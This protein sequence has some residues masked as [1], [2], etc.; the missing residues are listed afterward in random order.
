MTDLAD[1]SLHLMSLLSEDSKLKPKLD[2]FVKRQSAAVEAEKHLAEVQKGHEGAKFEIDDYVNRKKG[3]L[4]EAQIAHDK[5]AAEA[6]KRIEVNNA[7]MQT[8]HE[9][10]KQLKVHQQELDKQEDDLSRR[11]L[12]MASLNREVHARMEKLAK[13]EAALADKHNKLRAAMGD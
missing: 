10:E 8:R 3:E 2:E 12:A 7:Q 13:G 9:W 5:A 1:A 4:N 6:A 11:E